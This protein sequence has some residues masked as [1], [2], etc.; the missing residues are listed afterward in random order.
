MHDP[1]FSKTQFDLLYGNSKDLVFFLILEE[2]SFRYVYVNPSARLIFKESPINRYL[3]EMVS[4]EHLTEIHS[5]YM[6]AIE[7][8]EESTYQDFF[9]F[10]DVQLVNETT[11]KSILYENKQYILAMTREVSVEKEIEEKYAFMQSLLTMTVDPTIVVTSEG[12]IFDMNPKFEDV[13]GYTLKDW[14]GKHYLNLPFVPIDE[15]ESVENYVESNLKGEAKSSVL[16]KRM[17]TSGDIG[18]FLVSYSPIR[19]DGQVV[20]MYILLQEV[21]N[22]IELKESLRSTRNILESYQRAISSAAMV[23]MVSPNGLIDY[24]NELFVQITGFNRDEIIGEPF[25]TLN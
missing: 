9:L 14:R 2:Q 25:Q 11:V 12:K 18:T 22:E 17:K 4:M 6:H 10:S 7:N 8:Q 21:S 5:N 3:H 20:A 13:F 24:V 16:V 19:K 1:F 23:I 15:R